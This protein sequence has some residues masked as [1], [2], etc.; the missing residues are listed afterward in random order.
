MSKRPIGKPSK[1]VYIECFDSMRN[2]YDTMVCAIKE[3]DPDFKCMDF[4]TLTQK[5]ENLPVCIKKPKP[6][7]ITIETI[8]TFDNVPEGHDVVEIV[9]AIYYSCSRFHLVNG[10][11]IKRGT[12]IMNILTNPKEILDPKT[13]DW[14][15]PKLINSFNSVLWLGVFLDMAGS[16]DIR[17]DSLYVI[18]KKKE[19]KPNEKSDENV[20]DHEES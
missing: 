7:N 15:I 2:F 9:S 20:E 12:S 13:F 6:P 16:K 1:R 17:P 18:G 8:L 5:L 3:D 10:M 11:E 19:R 4:E 14:N